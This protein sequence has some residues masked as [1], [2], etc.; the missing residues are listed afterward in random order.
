LGLSNDLPFSGLG[1]AK[2][3]PRFYADASAATRSAATACSTAASQ[4]KQKKIDWPQDQSGIEQLIVRLMSPSL[5]L[6][7]GTRDG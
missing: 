1:A 4:A 6:A 2:P 7:S 5:G 3:A